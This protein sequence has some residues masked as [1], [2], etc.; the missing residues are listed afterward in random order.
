MAYWFNGF[1][2]RPS[3]ER[4]TVL[5]ADAVWREIVAPFIGVGLRVNVSS[6]VADDEPKPDEARRLLAEFGLGIAT[7]WLYLSYVTWAGEID[8]VYGVGAS[9]GREFGPVSGSDFDKARAA[10]LELMGAF[11]IAPADALNFPPFTRGFWGE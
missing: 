5:P 2:A 1:L 4:P 8:S 6:L 9:G 7:D 3:I 10:Y 11:G